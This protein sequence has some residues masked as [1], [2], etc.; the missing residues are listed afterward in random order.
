MMTSEPN[1]LGAIYQ[2]C[3]T[4]ARNWLQAYVQHTDTIPLSFWEELS[5]LKHEAVV[6]GNQLSAKATWCLEAIGK[7]QE[8]F[9]RSFKYMSS[10]DFKEGW[11]L[12]E[13]CQN[14]I[15][16]LD[17][18]FTEQTNEFGIEHVRIHVGRFQDL[19]PFEL[20]Y[21]PAFLHKIIR[22]STCG[23]QLSLRNRCTHIIGE[24]YD[25]EMCHNVIEQTKILHLSLVDKPR[26]KYAVIF[27]EGNDD[28]RLAH[29]KDLVCSL[30]TPWRCWGYTQE[31]RRAYPKKDSQVGRNEPC[32]CGSNRKYKSCCLSKETVSHHFR[33]FIGEIVGSVEKESP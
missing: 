10:G 20:G 3:F 11:D 4:V 30:G 33:I 31:T 5:C 29:L 26:H 8:N 14:E 24:I 1:L 19:F 23:L 21:S 27:P 15:H 6:S 9:V 13:R 2:P 25:G 12:L 22:C 28:T 18:H 17:R 7:V 32:P 16:F